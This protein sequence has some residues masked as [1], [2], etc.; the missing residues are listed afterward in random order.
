MAVL[1]EFDIVQVHSFN[2]HVV[3]SYYDTLIN[4]SFP[5]FRV[6]T[7]QKDDQV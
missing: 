4:K 1:L 5:I 7:H 2:I 6:Q 3:V